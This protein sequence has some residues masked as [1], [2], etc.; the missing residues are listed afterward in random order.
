VHRHTYRLTLAY[1]GSAFYGFSQQQGRHTVEGAL[2]AALRETMPE[3]PRVAVA[4][5]T[6]RGVHALGQVVSFWSREPLAT[7]RL[8]RSI[9]AQGQGALV[10]CALDEVARSFHA[11]FSATGRRYV[12][13][14]N[15]RELDAKHVSA[16]LA[17]LEGRRDFHAFSRRTAPGASTVRSLRHASATRVAPDRLRFDFA[18]DGFLRR[19]CRVMV[20]TALRE[21]RDGAGNDALLRLC[22]LGDRSAT[23]APAEPGRLYLTGVDY[24]L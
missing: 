16:M 23:E 11:S 19:Q 20:A 5:R 1:D 4:G 2:L 9:E 10:V 21:A 8:A 13:L 14:C 17:G 3:L 7:R 6:D 22:E 18:A 15:D 24:G 12:Y